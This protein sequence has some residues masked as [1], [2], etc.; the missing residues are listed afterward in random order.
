MRINAFITDGPTVRDC[1][2]TQLEFGRSSAN[3]WP[4]S[5]GLHQ[6]HA[7]YVHY[8]TERDDRNG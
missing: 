3:C 5:V 2:A 1:T 8:R 4:G 6:A 7:H